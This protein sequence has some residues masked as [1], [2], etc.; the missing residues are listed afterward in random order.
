MAEAK[1][2]KRS[3]SGVLAVKRRHLATLV[4]WLSLPLHGKEARAR[5]RVVR[6]FVEAAQQLDE[7]RLEIIKRFA[8]LDADGNLQVIDEEFAPGKT[9]KVY[10]FKSP[11]ERDAAEV[12]IN[13]MKDEEFK[14]DITQANAD[15]IAVARNLILNRVAEQFTFTFDETEVYDTVCAAFENA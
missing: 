4:D 6:T 11:K 7:D 5:N 10:K 13:E 15:D 2:A 14:L 9:R 3:G 1:K 8:D 12:E